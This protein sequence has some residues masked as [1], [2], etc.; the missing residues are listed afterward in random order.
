M[1]QIGTNQLALNV[2]QT[3][4][5]NI[6]NRR[7]F[8][9]FAAAAFTTPFVAR[10]GQAQVLQNAAMRGAIDAADA[11]FLPDTTDDQSRKFAAILQ[12]ASDTNQPVFLPPGNYVVSNL[13]LPKKVRISG[14]SGASRIIYGGDGF[15]FLAEDTEVLALDGVSFDGANRPLGDLSQGLLEARR[16][17]KVSI[18]GCEIDGASKHAAVLENCSGRIEGN[19]ISGAADAA[20]WS[21]EGRGISVRDNEISDCSNGGILVHRWQPGADNSIISGN[22][23]ERIGARN[24]GT[25]QYGN[26]INVFRGHGVQIANNHVSGCA[27]SA[28]RCNSASNA[29]ITGNTCLNSG[30]TALYAE[31]RFEGSIIANNLI[32]GAA[33]GISVVNFNEGGRLATVS[34]NIVRNLRTEGPYP[35]EG[36]G[37]GIGISVEA[38]TAVTGNTVDGAPNIGI[39]LGWGPYLRNVTVSSN[40]IRQAGEGIAVSVTEGSGKAVITG[41]VFDKIATGAIFGHDHDKI[42]SGDM[43]KHGA[44]GYSNVMVERNDVF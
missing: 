18:D 3:S 2:H 22:R 15:L 41:N 26:G 38:D 27:F 5:T 36:S 34:G 43:A 1:F 35:A 40:V 25:G 33:N 21:V 29:V 10:R 23:V 9:G 16:V 44:Q 37:F 8:L 11:G 28:I 13:R 30:E 17:A 12:K 14:V 4:M 19:R 42:V 20:I 31:F 7:R 39:A 32:D 24:S 6:Q